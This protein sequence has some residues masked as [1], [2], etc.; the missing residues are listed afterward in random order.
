MESLLTVWWRMLVSWAEIG[1]ASCLLAQACLSAS[2]RG[3]GG[4]GLYAVSYLSF[5]IL[6]ILCSVSSPGCELEPFAGKFSFFFSLLI[7]QF[8]V[9][10]QIGL[11]LSDCPQGI[12]A[13][14]LS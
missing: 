8:G 4:R 1:A 10:S 11:A 2:G 3:D 12:Q 5:G 6:S 7:L 9:L 13:Q 14:S